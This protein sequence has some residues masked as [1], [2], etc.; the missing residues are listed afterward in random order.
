MGVKKRALAPCEFYGVEELRSERRGGGEEELMNNCKN[1]LSTYR[2][3]DISCRVELRSG[4][5]LEPWGASIRE[6][7]YGDTPRCVF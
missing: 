1:D 6:G 7:I 4:R 5:S 3:R 2:D